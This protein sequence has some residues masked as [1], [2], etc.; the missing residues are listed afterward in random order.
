MQKL[1]FKNLHGASKQDLYINNFPKKKVNSNHCFSES[2]F[3]FDLSS[4]NCTRF[5]MLNNDSNRLNNYVI[6][7][8][9]VENEG[10]S[11]TF[12]F[13]IKLLRLD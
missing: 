11:V 8:E 12:N 5:L 6:F 4:C 7:G 10:R 3:E 9:T 13:P 1:S 2:L